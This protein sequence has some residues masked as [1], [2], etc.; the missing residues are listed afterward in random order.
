MSLRNDLFTCISQTPVIELIQVVKWLST[1]F[2]L[3][4][5]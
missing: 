1:F 3:W 5:W 4:L 2:F